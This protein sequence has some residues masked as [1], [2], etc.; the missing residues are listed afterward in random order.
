M[1]TST[2]I[3]NIYSVKVL[4][5]LITKVP[6]W[7][8]KIPLGSK[9]VTPGVFLDHIWKLILQEIPSD[10][11]GKSVL[12]VGTRDGGFA[13]ECEKRNAKRVLAFDLF[14]EDNVGKKIGEDIFIEAI[15][16]CKEVLDSKVEVKKLDLYDVDQL[17][18]KFDVVLFLGVIYHLYNPLLALEKLSKIC[19]EVLIGE[20]QFLISKYPICHL[21]VSSDHTGRM[22]VSPAFIRRY[23]LK[24]GFKK[25]EFHYYPPEREIYSDKELVGDKNAMKHSRGIFKCYK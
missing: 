9:I 19:N 2:E 12:D 22:L 25:F 24:L 15:K 16:I 18:E 21:P 4:Q 8:H 17:D 20:G 6:K 11:S 13:F 23:C 1:R 5:E 3:D 14:P 7:W 10:L